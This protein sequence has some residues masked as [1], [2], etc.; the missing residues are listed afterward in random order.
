M[1]FDP[2]IP[3]LENYSKK[4]IKDVLKIFVEKYLSSTF[5]VIGKKCK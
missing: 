5:F 1:C 2:V 3:L 4:I